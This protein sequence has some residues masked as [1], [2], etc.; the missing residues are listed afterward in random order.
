[1]FKRLLLFVTSCILAAG[2][3]RA[4]DNPYQFSRL[5][6]G[7][8]I[9]NNGINC[10]YKDSRG[11]MWFGTSS[12]LNRYDGYTFKVFKHSED[13]TALI[14]D[15]V[16]G[17][18]EGP[19]GKLWIATMGGLNIYD[20]AKDRFERDAD[21]QLKNMGIPDNYIWDIKKD[22]SGN[23]W[24]IHTSYGIYKYQKFKRRRAIY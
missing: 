8:G 4:Q 13:T 16:T 3:V 15:D 2:G 23:F 1:M 12:G 10:I 14:D 24:F 17:I 19:F 5:D 7:S 6:I 21:R 20:P 11:F 18:F 22:R 9:S